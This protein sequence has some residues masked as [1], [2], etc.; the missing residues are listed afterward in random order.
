MI[1]ALAPPFPRHYRLLSKSEQQPCDSA[2]EALP[3]AFGQPH[4]HVGLGLRSLRRGV[5]ECR[6]SPALRIGFTRHGDRL[7]L[8]T[9]GSH[10]T[11][12]RWLR[13]NC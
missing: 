7:L 8:H 3:F 10:D 1:L 2:V 6:A 13:V 11:I 12:R 4:R 5:Y 9:V